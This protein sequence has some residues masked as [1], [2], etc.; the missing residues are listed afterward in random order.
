MRNFENEVLVKALTN[1]GPVTE[2]HVEMLKDPKTPSGY[3]WS[4]SKGPSLMLSGGT[5]CTAEVITRWQ[6]PITLVFPSLRRVFGVT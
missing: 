6:K 4:S 2:L 5:L 3:Q 1:D